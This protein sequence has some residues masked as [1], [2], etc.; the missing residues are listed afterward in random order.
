MRR[1]RQRRCG[2]RARGS[3]DIYGGLDVLCNVAGVGG[4]DLFAD[5]PGD[6]RRTIDIDLTAVID[7]TRHGVRT[8]RR[9]GHGGAIVQ[10]ASLIG[11][12]P[13]AAAPV[14]AAAKAG[15]VHFTRSLADLAD[16]GI[17]VNAVCPE[18]VD[19]AMAHALGEDVLADLRTSGGILTPEQI[20]EH[21]VELIED[22]TR[23]GAILQI[24]ATDEPTYVT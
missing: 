8:M 10:V 7:A 20:A 4:G 14:Y 16:E 24:T 19:T 21:I 15:V 17:R 23:A 11:L 2:R 18:L 1:D 13:M 12:H 5:D 9:T 6:W 3:V 22:D